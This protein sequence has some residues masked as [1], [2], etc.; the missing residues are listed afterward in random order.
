MNTT[1]RSDVNRRRFLG[2]MVGALLALTTVAFAGQHSQKETAPT[3][4]KANPQV[5]MVIQNRGTIIIELFPNAAPKTVA[6]ILALI[7]RKFYD[8]ILFHRVIPEFVAQAGDPASIH[9]NGEKIRHLPDIEVGQKFGLGGGGSGHTVPLEANL[10]NERGTV[11][12][13]RSE[14]LS[15]GDSQFFF[16]LVPNH[17]LDANY[18]VFGK[19]LKGLDVVDKIQQGD[20]IKTMH[21]L[22]K[23]KTK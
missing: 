8:G 1:S 5:E 23:A 13:A 3:V 18:C 9:V 7:N 14:E 15:S 20:R 6:H 17:S 22:G 16:N 2:W 11:A 19:V 21:V 4:T 10:P 12:L